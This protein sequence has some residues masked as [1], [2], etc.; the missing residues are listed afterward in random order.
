MGY[1]QG[2]RS[3]NH[4][5]RRLPYRLL[6][7]VLASIEQQQNQEVGAQGDAAGAKP[8]PG[9]EHGHAR[10]LQRPHGGRTSV[11]RS[12]KA[13]GPAHITLGRYR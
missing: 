8:T 7:A 4:G 9:A 11:P 13:Q 12:G 10:G 3:T 6:I 2:S 5:H 1:K